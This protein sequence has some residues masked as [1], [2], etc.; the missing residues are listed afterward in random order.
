[1]SDERLKQIKSKINMGNNQ[2][3]I[4]NEVLELIYEIEKLKEEKENYAFAEEFQ[5]K[6]AIRSGKKEEK[7][8]KKIDDA[9]KYVNLMRDYQTNI[10]AD[11]ILE[12]LEKEN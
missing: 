12:I 3:I 8:L 9:I 6:T 2:S 4:D 7:L 1:M 10:F 11:G 5:R